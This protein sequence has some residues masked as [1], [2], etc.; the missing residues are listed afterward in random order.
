M[1]L[2]EYT[3]TDEHSMTYN[4]FVDTEKF[5]TSSSQIIHHIVNEKT[6]FYYIDR[7]GDKI[8][9]EFNK[10]NIKTV[11][12]FI[13]TIETNILNNKIPTF[14]LEIQHIKN[15]KN[16]EKIIEERK[17][18]I[19]K[20]EP[21]WDAENKTT[22]EIYKAATKQITDNYLNLKSIKRDTEIKSF[23]CL[24]TNWIEIKQHLLNQENKSEKLKLQIKEAKALYYQ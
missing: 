21:T 7:D 5:F 10:N 15:C 1:S 12:K 11:N 23:E 9:M 3:F 4:S 13:N 20:Y 6:H 18:H 24:K 2:V 22:P 17:K 14:I 19:E 16:I 8:Y